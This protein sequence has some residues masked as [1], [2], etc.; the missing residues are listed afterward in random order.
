MPDWRGEKRKQSRSPYVR[1]SAKIAERNAALRALFP[2]GSI[3]RYLPLK[4]RVGGGPWKVRYVDPHGHV[5]M[6]LVKGSGITFLYP[7]EEGPDDWT[8]LDPKV[9]Q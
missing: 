5:V 8:R 7:Y 4:N 1:W 9:G 6:D 2:E 3:W